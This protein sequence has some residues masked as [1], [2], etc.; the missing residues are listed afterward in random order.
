MRALGESV[1][2]APLSTLAAA[3]WKVTSARKQY[4][5]ISAFPFHATQVFK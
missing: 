2:L 3:G 4:S 5:G 1:H